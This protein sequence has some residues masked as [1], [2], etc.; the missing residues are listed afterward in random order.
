MPPRTS[1]KP[2][3]TENSNARSCLQDLEQ[4]SLNRRW[5]TVQLKPPIFVI[6]RLLILFPTCHTSRTWAIP[7][8]ALVLVLVWQWCSVSDVDGCHGTLKGAICVYS[9]A[10]E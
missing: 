8:I 9:L 2:E 6:S 7:S 3:E 10:E 5:Y 4:R 1:D